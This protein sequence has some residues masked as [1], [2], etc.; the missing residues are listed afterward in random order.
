MMNPTQDECLSLI[1]YLCIKDM[2]S[3]CYLIELISACWNSNVVCMHVYISEWCVDFGV[4]S[5]GIHL[6]YKHKKENAI[7]NRGYELGSGGTCL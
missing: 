3:E 2:K 6:L 5:T 1:K 7:K 4:Y